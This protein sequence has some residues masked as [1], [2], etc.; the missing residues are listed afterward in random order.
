M[1]PIG[2]PQRLEC[3]LDG[4]PSD[5]IVLKA[6]WY[7]LKIVRTRR[8]QALLVLTIRRAARTAN[9]ALPFRPPPYWLAG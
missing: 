5:A 8:T 3:L 9:K 4:V 7:N 2:K 1:L 6:I